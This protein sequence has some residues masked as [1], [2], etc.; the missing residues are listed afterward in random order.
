MTPSFDYEHVVT[1]DETN[2]IGNVYFVNHLRWQGHCRELFLAAHAPGV[3]DALADSLV[4]VTTQCS[5]EYFAELAALDR[6]VVQMRLAALQGNRIRMRFDYVREN[7]HGPE[8][9]ARG[10]QE[11]ACLARGTNG[12]GPVP[13]PDELRNAL[14]PYRGGHG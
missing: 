11:V 9:V 6:V 13:V 3:L 12:V 1:F 7:G 8:V 14:E 5:C 10:E 4:L 2:V